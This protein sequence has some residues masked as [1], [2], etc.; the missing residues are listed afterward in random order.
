MQYE[1]PQSD[2]VTLNIDKGKY[3]AFEVKDVDRYQSDIDLMDDWADDAGE[4]MKIEIDRGILGT[5][6]ADVDAQNKG[7]TAGRISGDIDLGT[8]G[9][10]VVLVKGAAGAGETEVLDFIVD[11]GTVLDEQNVPQTG[12]WL[13]MPAWACALIK[14]S[15]LNNANEAGDAQSILRNG[16]IGMVDRFTIYSSNLVDHVTDGGNNV[17]NIIA[18]HRAG[19][20]FASQ[21]TEMETLKNP[22][23]FG[24]LVRG[25]NVYGFKVIEGKYLA[26]GYAT[27]A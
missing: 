19:L 25:L 3:F 8:T 13:V 27:K 16:R 15:D 1:R 22:N 7:A 21:M 18:G 12:R 24:D 20:T 23:D 6:Y 11:L 2:S 14:K 26:H 4:Q 9:S 5:I 10:P 17:A